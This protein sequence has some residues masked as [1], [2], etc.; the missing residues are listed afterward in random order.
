M[1]EVM[2]RTHYRAYQVPRHERGHKMYLYNN[3]IIIYPY[4]INQNHI[5]CLSNIKKYFQYFRMWII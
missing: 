4:Q 3:L 2:S 5:Y 1:T